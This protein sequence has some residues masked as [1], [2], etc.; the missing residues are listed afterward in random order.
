[1]PMSVLRVS[2]A[3]SVWLASRCQVV[4]EGPLNGERDGFLDRPGDITR[5]R[6]RGSLF[7]R[8]RGDVRIRGHGCPSA[9]FVND[10]R[11]VWSAVLA[12]V[13]VVCS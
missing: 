8:L 10:H 7:H 11:L 12:V 9:V 4:D 13:K 6:R 5:G 2:P 1:M 3:R